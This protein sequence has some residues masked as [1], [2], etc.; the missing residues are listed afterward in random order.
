MIPRIIPVLL[1]SNGGLYKTVR[2]RNPKYIG[3]PVNAV[4][5]FNDKSVDEIIVL[6]YNATIESRNPDFNIIEDIANQCFMP[7][8]YGGGIRTI[9]DVCRIVQCGVEKIAINSAAV[10]NYKF[11]EEV[12]G[13]FGSSTVV[14]SMD[15]KKSFFG[16]Y[17]VVTRSGNKSAGIK[18]DDFARQ[19]ERCGAGEI[20]VNSVARDGMM[21]G[22]D[23]DL[24]RLVSGAVNVPVIACGGAGKIEHFREAEDN[25]ASAMAAGSMFVFHGKHRGILIN[26]PDEDSLASVFKK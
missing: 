26:Y 1:I 12:A 10:E 24:I 4:R 19:M 23:L 17:E 21:Q 6:D 15:V 16:E 11:V 14:L 13:M 5:V 9:S 7:L 8:C 25:G 2:F 22:Y 18:P 20:L 3:D